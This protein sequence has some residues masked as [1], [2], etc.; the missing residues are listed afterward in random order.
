MDHGT[1]LIGNCVLGIK[2]NLYFFNNVKFIKQQQNVFIN[3]VRDKQF[4][5]FRRVKQ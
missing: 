5:D 4:D 3:S 1:H 2:S